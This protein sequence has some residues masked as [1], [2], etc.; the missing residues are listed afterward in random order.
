MTAKTTYPVVWTFANSV[1]TDTDARLYWFK[2]LP[3]SA[4]LIKESFRAQSTVRGCLPHRMIDYSTQI[5]NG[6]DT[7]AYETIQ[8]IL[9]YILSW[10]TYHLAQNKLSGTFKV[11]N[12]VAVKKPFPHFR[13]DLDDYLVLDPYTQQVAL[14]KLESTTVSA[15]VLEKTTKLESVMKSYFEAANTCN[16]LEKTGNKV[17]FTDGAT[18]NYTNFKKDSKAVPLAAYTSTPINVKFKYN[19]YG[20]IKDGTHKSVEFVVKNFPCA[21]SGALF[22]FFGK[23]IN[24]QDKDRT[25]LGVI[26]QNS[27]G[28]WSSFTAEQLVVV[29]LGDNVASR[30]A[31]PPIDRSKLVDQYY[32]AYIKM[33]I[34]H[35]ILFSLSN[36]L[37]LNVLQSWSASVKDAFQV[38]S[39]A[40]ENIKQD[41]TSSFKLVHVQANP[42]TWSTVPKGTEDTNIGLSLG[43]R[44]TKRHKGRQTTSK[45]KILVA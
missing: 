31:A 19:G 1:F 39:T 15:D 30:A 45:F 5:G 12:V 4:V 13:I 20:V 9:D 3:L 25:L 7:K 33:Q 32:E 22:D 34:L 38:V 10:A 21:S 28:G 2:R 27:S 8:P 40:T 11:T 18:I 41:C 29:T 6:S 42:M 37:K 43:G 16:I 44:R 36:M 23:L 24:G 17:D 14:Q 26:S 35:T